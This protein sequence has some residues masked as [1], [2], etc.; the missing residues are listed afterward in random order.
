MLESKIR[1]MATDV[2]WTVQTLQVVSLMNQLMYSL[3]ESLAHGITMST[4]QRGEHLLAA[5]NFASDVE[6]RKIGQKNFQ[7][8]IQMNYVIYQSMRYW[9]ASK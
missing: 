8:G 7:E 3:H 5:C 4:V 6:N 2:S 1:T 9:L